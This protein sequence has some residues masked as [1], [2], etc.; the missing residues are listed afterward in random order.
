MSKKKLPT[1]IENRRIN[2]AEQSKYER[3]LSEMENIREEKSRIISDQQSKPSDNNFTNNDNKMQVPCEYLEKLTQYS[4]ASNSFCQSCTNESAYMGDI[5]QSISSLSIQSRESGTG[6]NE[7]AST[8]SDSLDKRS[9]TNV[10][11]NTESDNK[12]VDPTEVLLMNWAAVWEE[13]SK[14]LATHK[15]DQCTT[16]DVKVKIYK[17][18]G[19]RV[20]HLYECKN[21]PW[22]TKIWTTPKDDK[23]LDINEALILG[24]I[25]TGN[26]YTQMKKI[27]TTAGIRFMSNDTYRN[28]RDKAWN[29][30]SNAVKESMKQAGRE[31]FEIALKNGK[32]INNIGLVPV[33]AD[34][35]W[36]KRSYRSGSHNSPAGMAFI[37]GFNTGKIL[38]CETKDMY[39]SVCDRANRMNKTPKHH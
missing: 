5:E 36:M 6:N 26:G 12:N 19:N 27:F 16:E 14:N 33:I 10:E 31:G 2:E 8:I 11:K 38:W 22:N 25:N 30:M 37:I 7:C 21:C 4:D 29:I 20:C 3:L 13:L 18:E 34:G 23:N 28:R 39:C 15:S 9:T 17:R 35:S 24:A 1:V 32:V